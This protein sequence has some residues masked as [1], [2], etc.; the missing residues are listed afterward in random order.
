MVCGFPSCT[1]TSTK[2][3][4]SV[5][6]YIIAPL[7]SPASA[8]CRIKHL[9]LGYKAICRVALQC[10]VK[11]SRRCQL[12]NA[13]CGTSRQRDIP[14][15]VLL[16]GEQ[17]VRSCP[18]SS[19]YAVTQHL[20]SILGRRPPTITSVEIWLAEYAVSPPLHCTLYPPIFWQEAFA[21]G[22]QLSHSEV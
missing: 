12:Q 20:Y 3:T 21:G 18:P 17:L 16:T 2:H 9:I 15:N 7:Q 5:H 10:S 8:T 11:F 13:K 6:S 22:D 4:L 19:L 1:V 14:G